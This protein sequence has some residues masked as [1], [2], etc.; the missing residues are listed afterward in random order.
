MNTFLPIKCLL[1]R[2]YAAHKA[3]IIT[4]T[5]FTVVM[6]TVLKNVR[7][8]WLL[9]AI[10]LYAVKL[11]PTGQILTSLLDT[12]SILLNDMAITF[13]KGIMIDMQNKVKI[14]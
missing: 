1:D 3:L 10:L 12:A 7:Q 8:N 14:V 4:K 13:K 6:K 2:A 11:K 9:A 5:V